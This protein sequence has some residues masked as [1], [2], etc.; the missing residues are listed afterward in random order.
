MDEKQDTQLT[1]TSG[2]Q[3]RQA[4]VFGELVPLPSG[5]VARLRKLSLL[6]FMRKGKIPDPLSAVINEMVA[7]KRREAADLDTFSDFADLLDLICREAFVEP[8]I[9]DD[10]QEDGEI[11]IEDIDFQDRMAVFNWSQKEIQFSVPTSEIATKSGSSG[12]S[13]KDLLPDPAE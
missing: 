2:A 8:K 4:R 6:G 11:S 13:A 3:W 12:R 7:G 1:V 10:P 5:N 9:V